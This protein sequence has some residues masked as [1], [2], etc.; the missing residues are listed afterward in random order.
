MTNDNFDD[1]GYIRGAIYFLSFAEGF[2]GLAKTEVS[3]QDDV[4]HLDVI[5]RDQSPPGPAA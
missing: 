5:R 1:L 2:L 3:T 4:A